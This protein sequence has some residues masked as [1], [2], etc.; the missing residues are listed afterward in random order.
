V[1]LH[2]AAYQ[3]STYGAGVA[4]R[5]VDGYLTKPACTKQSSTVPWWSVDLGTQMDIGWVEVT[6]DGNVYYG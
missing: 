1:A 3:S 5:A 6:N 2:R 4:T